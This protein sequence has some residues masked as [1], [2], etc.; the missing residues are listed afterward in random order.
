M[1]CQCDKIQLKGGKALQLIVSVVNARSLM[2]CS[3]A[4]AEADRHDGGHGEGA[5]T[6]L[7]GSQRPE[8]TKRS[9]VG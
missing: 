2:C 7:L 5:G 3:F 9:K 8:N 6:N 1:L 4:P